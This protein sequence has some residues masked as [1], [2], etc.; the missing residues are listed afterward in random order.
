MKEIDDFRQKKVLVLGLGKSGYSAALL[1]HHLGAQV[2]LNDAQDLTH[3]KRAQQLVDAGIEIVSGHHD[4]A[5]FQKHFALMVK[6]PGIGYDNPMVQR[7][8]HLKL[9]IITEP[10]LAYRVSEAPF[11]C[12][13][14]SNG[15]TTTTTLIQLILDH[16]RQHGHAYKAGN[17]GIPASEVVQQATAQDDIVVETSSF[18]LL[19]VQQLKPKIA[20]LTNIYEAHLDYHKTRANYVKAKMNITKNQTATDYFVVNFDQAEWRQLSQQSQAQIIP[21]S[22]TNYTKQG[23]YQQDGT[24]YYR[25]EAIIP[26][27]EVALPGPHNIENCL[28]AIAVAKIMK[29]SNA[30]IRAV[31]STF[32]GVKHRI[33]YLTTKQGV[34]IYNDSKATNIEATK[35]ALNSFTEPTVLI[36]GGLDRGFQ[37]DELVA[38]MQNVK[39]IVL[40]GQT[41]HLM[42]AAAQKAHIQ[43]IKI[44]D[45]LDQAV[46][47]AWPLCQPGDVLLLSPAAASWDQFQTFEQRGDRFIQDIKDLGD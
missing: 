32:T 41:K 47:S 20:V 33:Q 4:V 44:V 6:N 11:I 35:V 13:T 18:Q 29:K 34:K 12:V 2:T 40:Y 45:N 10:E 5:L 24:L 7:A 9:P 42:A 1:L 14:G 39:A 43:T 22:R 28:A 27:A 36:A 3:N 19:G 38:S 31:L 26:V 23:A 46:V 37:F 30:D 8:L 25:G 15:K 16:H 17:I 21:F